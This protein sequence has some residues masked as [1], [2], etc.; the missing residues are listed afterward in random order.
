MNWTRIK[1]S[2]VPKL[3]GIHIDLDLVNDRVVSVTLSDNAGNELRIDSDYTG[4]VISTPTP[5]SVTKWRVNGYI[6]SIDWSVDHADEAAA[7]ESALKLTTDFD[8]S[9]TALT[10]TPVAVPNF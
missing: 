4:L 10:V 2:T 7:R 9:P 8:L 5:P 6:K 3:D 1:S